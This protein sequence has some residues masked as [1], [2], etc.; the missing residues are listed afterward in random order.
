MGSAAT[1]AAR[2]SQPGCVW[3]ARQASSQRDTTAPAP[4]CARNFAG[5]AIRPLSS[6][7]CRYS[8]VNTR[9]GSL[10]CLG[11]VRWVQGSGLFCRSDSPLP[12]TLD[13]FD[14]YY[15]L[16]RPASMENSPPVRVSARLGVTFSA[17]KPR[18]SPDD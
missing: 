7:V 6:T 9:G 5:T 2:P 15:V 17:P 14:A 3:I 16:I 18:R 1:Y 4:S 11:L 10:D 8:P 13:H 12:T